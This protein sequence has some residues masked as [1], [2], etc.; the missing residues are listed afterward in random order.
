MSQEAI[1]EVNKLIDDLS[2]PEHM[3]KEQ[4]RVFLAEIIADCHIKLECVEAELAE[5]A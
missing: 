1:D 4:Y 2:S 5:E 3:T